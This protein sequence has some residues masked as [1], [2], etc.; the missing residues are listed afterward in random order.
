MGMMW[1]IEERQRLC[2]VETI[3]ALFT[4]LKMKHSIADGWNSPEAKTHADMMLILGA[5]ILKL[6]EKV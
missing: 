2:G 5:M 4:E 3:E 6:K 1:R